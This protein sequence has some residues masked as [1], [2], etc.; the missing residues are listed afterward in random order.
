MAWFWES[1]GEGEFQTPEVSSIYEG[2]NGWEADLATGLSSHAEVFT[3]EITQ[4]FVDAAKLVADSRNG[5]PS[6]TFRFLTFTGSKAKE[7]REK[8]GVSDLSEKYKLL[9][10]D[11]K[12]SL[13]LPE[14][15]LLGGQQ[16][17]DLSILIVTESG[18]SG[19]L[20]PW[21]RDS[22]YRDNDGKVIM[23]RMRDALLSSAGSNN[24]AS[25]GS[26]GEGKKAIIAASAPRTLITY[27][28][29]DSS[30]TD[31]G[32]SRRLL[33]TTYWRPYN[34]ES[35]AYSGL[36]ML[37]RTEEGNSRPTPLKNKDAD[38][39]VASLGLPGFEVRDA[40]NS[41][42]WGTS[43]IFLEPVVDAEEVR[44][45]IERNWW[46]LIVDN[47]VDFHVIDTDNQELEVNPNQKPYLAPFIRGWGLLGGKEVVD[48]ENETV[49]A[50]SAPKHDKA[51][52]LAL[53]MD[54]TETGWSKRD[55]E[56]NRSLVALI[57][58]GMLISYQ[59]FPKSR[60][61]TEPFVR[62]VYSVSSKDDQELAELLRQ[63]EPP[64]H[65]YWNTKH[66]AMDKAALN[67]A[68]SVYETISISVRE[69]RSRFVEE[70]VKQSVDLALFD[71]MLSVSG[72][73]RSNRKVEPPPPPPSKTDWTILDEGASVREFDESTRYAVAERSV[74]LK[75][76]RTEQMV[77]ITFG[78]KVEGDSGKLE[79]EDGLFRRTEFV[80]KGFSETQSGVI[81][82]T[83]KP[84]VSIK[85][86]WSSKPY[87]EMWTLQPF[88]QVTKLG[89]S[90][91]GVPNEVGATEDDN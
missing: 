52:K 44:D 28:A 77:Q 38:D 24:K 34:H 25:L 85:M 79:Q 70:M 89:D 11:Q 9:D 39:F 5:A 49:Q 75:P 66:E 87:S 73:S 84:G 54:F 60:N 26:Y 67:L 57:R 27:T 63:V 50:V 6:L 32:A 14:S 45:S 23:R 16:A 58:D 74:T 59:K 83:L 78:W 13:K 47:E 51:G 56:T 53:M 48:D 76:N 36:A 8:L 30:S 29:F 4:N 10:S 20:G 91:D 82:G 12:R 2:W 68:Q 69:F 81:V 41:R 17:D 65:N 3:R 33:G 64:L 62:G 46:P 15:K 43:Q 55:P 7:L 72:G 86:K 35:S 61:L 31:D 1:R 90:S 22:R 19:M 88:V 21:A 37:G 40:S 80:S 42:N 71:E 18:T